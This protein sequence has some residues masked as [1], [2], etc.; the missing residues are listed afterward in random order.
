MPKKSKSGIDYNDDYRNILT[1]YDKSKNI[2]NARIT[3]YEKSEIIGQRTTQIANGAIPM[4]KINPSENLSV[5]DIVMREYNE[6]KIP[7][8]IERK[9]GDD[10][11]EYWKF[12]D[13]IRN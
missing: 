5:K 4:V 1:H 9:I 7:F 6:G 3:R 13:L 2:S 12:A 11:I 8:I 10:L